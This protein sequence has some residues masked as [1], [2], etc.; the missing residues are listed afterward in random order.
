[1]RVSQRLDYTLR[2]L[3]SLAQLPPGT[4]VAAGELA[5]S[6][7]LPRRFVEQQFSAL[8]RAGLVD[9]RRGAGGGCALTRPVADVT[10]G[11]V[12]RAVQG[13]VI[14]VP[15]VTGS[16]VSDMWSGAAVALESALDSFTLADLASSQK[17]LDAQ[18]APMYYI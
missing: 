11:D 16:A 18:A 5:D 13:T 10:V 15:R 6:L 3:T 12:V 17:E 2:G 4:Y 8:A 14:D 9:C 7:A 1:V